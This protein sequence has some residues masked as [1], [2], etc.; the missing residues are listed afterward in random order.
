VDREVRN[1]VEY[2]IPG[3]FY[4]FCSS[5]SPEMFTQMSLWFSLIKP[6]LQLCFFAEEVMRIKCHISMKRKVK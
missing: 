3:L 5:M 4:I 2:M 6:E 1:T